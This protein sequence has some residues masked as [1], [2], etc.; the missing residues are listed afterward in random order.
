MSQNRYR[1]LKVKYSTGIPG[2]GRN[3]KQ[4]ANNFNARAAII[5]QDA[6]ACDSHLSGAA[7]SQT[8]V[9]QWRRNLPSGATVSPPDRNAAPHPP[10]YDKNGRFS[11][12]KHQPE[13]GQTSGPPC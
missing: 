3:I 12:Q 9:S 10:R 2:I 13:P 8:S 5:L 7:I 6:A 11:I 4:N 1:H